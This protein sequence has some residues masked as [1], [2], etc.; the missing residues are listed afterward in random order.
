MRH[1]RGLVAE[2][3]GVSGLRYHRTFMAAEPGTSIAALAR[4]FHP[5]LMEAL[6]PTPFEAMETRGRRF[7]VKREDLQATGSFKVRGAL[8]KLSLLDRQRARFGVVCASAG[9]HGKGVAWAAARL[10]ILATVVV[11][12]GTPRVKKQGIIDLGAELIEL[13]DKPGYDAAEAFALDL[14]AKRSAIFVSPFDDPAIQAGGGGTIALEILE[15]LPAVERIVIPVGG[16]GLAAGLAAVI[17]GENALVDI[18]GVQSS[19]SPAMSRSIQDGVAH[20][21]WPAAETLAEGLEGGVAQSTFEACRMHLS[22]V[23]EVSEDAI[24][25][26]ITRASRELGITLEGSAATCLAA[27]DG[28]AVDVD[29]RTVVVFTGSNIDHERIDAL[30]LRHG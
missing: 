14:A 10:G 25:D 29:E 21:T 2:S 5:A 19:A 13:E 8:L 15:K 24:A 4:R 27:I 26:A 16:G 11:P 12:R 1:F 23:I 6:P 18:V 7:F 9:N 3:A 30:V 28:G 20:L 22:R 17:H